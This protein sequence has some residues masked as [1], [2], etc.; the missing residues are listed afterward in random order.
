MMTMTAN[1]DPACGF[2]ARNIGLGERLVDVTSL[3]NSQIRDGAT[4]IAGDE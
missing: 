2:C 4:V 3:L 1:I